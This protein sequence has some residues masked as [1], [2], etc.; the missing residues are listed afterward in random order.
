M[1][2]GEDINVK[3]EHTVKIVGEAQ[4]TGRTA[5]RVAGG[6]STDGFNKLTSS[7]NNVTNASG[8][9]VGGLNTAINLM[10]RASEASITESLQFGKS[11]NAL[12]NLGKAAVLTGEDMRIMV[13]A[14]ISTGDTG[15]QDMAKGN[16][17]ALGKFQDTL[18]KIKPSLSTN[19]LSVF[20]MKAIGLT[21]VFNGL[22]D[23]SSSFFDT[24]DAGVR[25]LGEL[26]NKISQLYSDGKLSEKQ[27]LSLASV[28]ESFQTGAARQKESKSII[29]IT[30]NLVADLTTLNTVTDKQKL[31]MEG[32]TNYNILGKNAQAELRQ[33]LGLSDTEASKYSR[34]ITDVSNKSEQLRAYNQAASS[35]LGIVGHAF[36]E[37]TMQMYWV[38]LGFL[39]MTMTATRANQ[40][41]LSAETRAN[42]LAKQLYSLTEA[43]KAINDAISDYGPDSEEAK[44]ATVAYQQALMDIE[45]QKKSL[46]NSL[47]QEQMMSMQGYMTQIPLLVN[48]IYMV[49][50]AYGALRGGMAAKMVMEQQ[51]IRNIMLSNAVTNQQSGT[52]QANT[53]AKGVNTG[54]TV[55]KTMATITDTAT[56]R[57]N[58]VV[59]EQQTSA[60]VR[61]SIARQIATL[62]LIGLATA[63]ITVGITSLLMAN[64][65]AE[66]DKQMKK[67]TED[68]QAQVDAWNNVDTSASSYND[69]LGNIATTSSNVSTPSISTQAATTGTTTNHIELNVSFPYANINNNMDVETITDTMYSTVVKKLQG[70]GMAF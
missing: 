38:S 43:Q 64:A 16:A 40:A 41:Q 54:T 22:K 52:E 5:D 4:G 21:E 27:L 33:E 2:A 57:I 51:T 48:T 60:L 42:S 63:A 3:I 29:S 6:V 58:T 12:T 26:G 49:Y 15:L 20:T 9:L 44:K 61:Q 19:E 28:V 14:M 70:V 62:G 39:F 11:T 32:L 47:V 30:P 34:T 50:T 46:R 25:T 68:A 35:T 37:V 17:E 31:S 56:G 55:A 24:S 59:I 18:Q 69:T 67:L 13:N 66:A 65:Q 45:L 10:N 7:M 1:S 23:G 36:R 53:V 8:N